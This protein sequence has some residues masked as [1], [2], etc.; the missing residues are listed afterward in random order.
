ML[1]IVVLYSVLTNEVR[2]SRCNLTTPGDW[3][4][5]EGDRAG[6]GRRKQW[7][8][9]ANGSGQNPDILKGKET[10]SRKKKI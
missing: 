10:V 3:G 6:G 9:K 7:D 5:T 4:V 8:G 1:E 2:C